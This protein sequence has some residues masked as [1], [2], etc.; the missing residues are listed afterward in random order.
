M[1]DEKMD[2]ITENLENETR[3]ILKEIDLSHLTAIMLL[4]GG[5]NICLDFIYDKGNHE[6]F[7]NLLKEKFPGSE[8]GIKLHRL[9]SI[10]IAE[11]Y[12]EYASFDEK[13]RNE[14]EN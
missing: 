8:M 6:E 5:M 1:T 4:M 10:R 7:Q 2:R 14:S 3:S 11:K 13:L 12:P 9:I